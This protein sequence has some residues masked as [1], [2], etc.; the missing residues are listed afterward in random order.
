MSNKAHY[1][2]SRESDLKG[3]LWKA[4]KKEYAKDRKE[5]RLDL[6]EDDLAKVAAAGDSAGSEHCPLA[7]RNYENCAICASYVGGICLA[8][9]R[10][11]GGK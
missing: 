5:Q 8:G 10:R 7:G 6:S 3:R 1:D 9:Y 2:F 4:V 11:G